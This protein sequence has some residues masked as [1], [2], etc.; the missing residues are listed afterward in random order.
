VHGAGG[1]PGVAL[2]APGGR[3]ITPNGKVRAAGRAA[4]LP[5]PTAKATY[6]GIQHPRPGRWTVLSDPKRIGRVLAQLTELG[7]GISLDDFGT[8]YSSLTHLK[9]LPVCELKL[10][11]R[12]RRMHRVGASRRVTETVDG[13]QRLVEGGV[14]EHRD[15]LI[16]AE[17]CHEVLPSDGRA[18]AFGGRN[19]DAVAGIVSVQRSGAGPARGVCC[20]RTSA[21]C[22]NEDREGTVIRRLVLAGRASGAKKVTFGIAD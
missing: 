2:I 10:D 21:R 16:S 13:G 3:Q 4:A 1:P 8:G 6:V 12:L 9:S 5:D 19:Q 20:A 14:G 11:R 18:Q 15:E 7:I 17:T 22:D